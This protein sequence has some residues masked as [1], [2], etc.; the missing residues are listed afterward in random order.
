MMKTFHYSLL[1]LLSLSVGVW[2][3]AETDG[4]TIDDTPS[5]DA[6]LVELQGHTA[7]IASAVFSQD[8]KKIV[9]ASSDDTVRMWDAQTG[10]ELHQWTQEF[11]LEYPPLSR[12][13]KKV[14]TGNLGEKG[15]LIQIW[16]A[17]SDSATF[18]RELR[19]Q[20]LMSIIFVSND[21]KKI[22]AT[23][24]E[25]EGRTGGGVELV[26]IWDTD[27][28][29]MRTLK[30]KGAASYGAHYGWQPGSQT[31]VSPDGTRIVTVRADDDGRSTVVVW[32]ADSGSANF[33]KEL[34]KLGEATNRPLLGRRLGRRSAGQDVAALSALFSPDGSKI[35]THDS[36]ETVRIWDVQSGRELRKLEGET[37]DFLSDG[38]KFATLSGDNIPIW[39]VST[40]KKLATIKGEIN[41]LF[42]PDGKKMVTHEDQRDIL[43]VWDSDSG[44]K[45]F[46]SRGVPYAFS[47]DSKR[48]VVRDDGSEVAGVRVLDVESGEGPQ[49]WEG[50]F[51][52]FSPDS[53]K[54]IILTY[55]NTACVW[56]LTQNKQN[57]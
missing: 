47:P 51:G 32:D 26:Q 8:G 20:E 7:E 54:I 41:I 5:T 34:R 4:Q 15:V 21:L 52:A 37:G 18:G 9:T 29:R 6:P 16:D 36:D 40:G 3:W 22:V 33:G 42:S 13:G 53:K 39:E 38:K 10:K 45:L 35:A 31:A 19:K 57:Q 11:L 2:T 30:P 12:D 55:S 48:L 50:Q 28:G 24:L 46:E 17:D 43:W 14:L 44:K 56:A 1:L 27:S 23:Y 25:E 49:R